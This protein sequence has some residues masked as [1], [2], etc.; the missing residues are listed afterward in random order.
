MTDL[1]VLGPGLDHPEF[2]E[3][4][5]PRLS[6]P[7]LI[8]RDFAMHVVSSFAAS[9]PQLVWS[10]LCAAVAHVGEDA[11]QFVGV[12]VLEE[13]LEHHFAPTFSALQREVGAGRRG[14]LDALSF[15]WFD[16]NRGP[17]YQLAQE[18]LESQG[19]HH[20]RRIHFAA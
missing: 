5:G 8:A 15:A 2:L 18:Y 14:L 6:D 9:H 10:H 3:V 20:G 16:N 12:T 19:R 17:N 4:A 13:L 11:R 7:D 1:L